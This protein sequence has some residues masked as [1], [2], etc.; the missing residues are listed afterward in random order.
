[1]LANI[2]NGL[3]IPKGEILF[4]LVK[5]KHISTKLLYSDISKNIINLLNKYYAPKTILVPTFT[6]FFTKTGIFNKLNTPSGVG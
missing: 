5:I 1:M 6:Y 3:E 2:L 4:L